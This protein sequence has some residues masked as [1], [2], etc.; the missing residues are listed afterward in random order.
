M[1]CFENIDGTRA[2]QWIKVLIESQNN[3]WWKLQLRCKIDPTN[4]ES[5]RKICPKESQHHF[6]FSHITIPNGDTA[7]TGWHLLGYPHDDGQA[8]QRQADQQHHQE[9]EVGAG[10]SEGPGGRAAVVHQGHLATRSATTTTTTTT[11]HY[12]HEEEVASYKYHTLPI[13]LACILVNVL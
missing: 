5:Y 12:P 13:I 4:S 10:R 8:G 7:Y 6:F 11:T 9:E 3:F 2:R 1:T